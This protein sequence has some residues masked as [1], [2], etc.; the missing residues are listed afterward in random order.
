MAQDEL[1]HQ[2]LAR[3]L[4]PIMHGLGFVRPESGI[5]TPTLTGS[6]SAGTITQSVRTGKW[7]RVGN[8]CHITGR[9]MVS[10]ISVAP[11]GDL[12][13]SS[14]PF[15]G[16]AATDDIAGG[17]S[18]AYWSANVANGYTQV[19]GIVLHTSSRIRV[20]RTGD[21]VS[22]ASVPGSELITGEWRFNGFYWVG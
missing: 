21:N 4:A 6:S 3:L 10:A 11:G 22:P 17:V 13:I 14:L 16:V 8:V 2:R 18:F 7:V 20:V 5:W 15:A 19:G 1:Y 12:E 9:I